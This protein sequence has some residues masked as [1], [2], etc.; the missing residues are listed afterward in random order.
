MREP[1]IQAALQ[2]AMP[3]LVSGFRLRRPRNDGGG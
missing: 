1:G 3:F 2:L